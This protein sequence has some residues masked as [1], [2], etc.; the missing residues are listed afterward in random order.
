MRYGE[1]L[2]NRQA[3]VVRQLATISTLPYAN[4]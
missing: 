1:L 3:R 2:R 4:R